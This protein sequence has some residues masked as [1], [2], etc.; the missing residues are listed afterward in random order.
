MAFDRTQFL[1]HLVFATRLKSSD[2]VRRNHLDSALREA[3]SI[4]GLQDQLEAID[5]VGDV[6]ETITYLSDFATQPAED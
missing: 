4:P 3:A 2:Q 1:C 6:A 5:L